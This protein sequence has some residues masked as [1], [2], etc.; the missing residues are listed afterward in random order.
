MA[1]YRA[2]PNIILRRALDHGIRPTP[3]AIARSTGIPVRTISRALNGDPV[4]ARTM[5]RLAEA[6]ATGLDDLFEPTEPGTAPASSLR[7]VQ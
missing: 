1:G 2:R 3:L 6:F 4:S 5:S 7:E